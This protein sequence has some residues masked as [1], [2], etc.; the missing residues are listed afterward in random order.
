MELKKITFFNDG[1]KESNLFYGEYI[2]RLTEKEQQ[3]KISKDR[4]TTFLVFHSG[5]VIVSGMTADIM[6][7]GYEYFLKIIEKCKNEIEEIL[8]I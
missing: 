6:R 8:E 1:I 4:Y 2:S 7:P 5:K 3:K